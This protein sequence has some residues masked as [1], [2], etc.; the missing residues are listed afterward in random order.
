MPRYPGITS[1]AFRHPLDREAEQAL[2]ALPGFDL[3]ARKFLEFTVDRPQLIYNMGNS[4]QVGPRQYASVYQI[5]RE[6]LQSL[7]IYPEPALF[8]TQTP[9]VNAYTV[10][11]E[12]PSV[13]VT[14]GALDLLGETELR[15]VIAHELGHF[16]CGHTTLTQM[17]IWAIQA[18]S[19]VGQFTFGISNILT[20]VALFSAFY[21]WKRKAELS[22]DRA[23][24]LVT[25][26]LDAVMMTLIMLAGGSGS[27][28]QEISLDEF[29]RQAR[30]YQALDDDGLNQIYKFLL[31]NNLSQGVFTSH[32]FPVERVSFIE[33]W[34]N[35]DEYRRIRNGDYAQ[36]PAEGSVDISSNG[37]GVAEAERLRQQIEELQQQIN[38][39][40]NDES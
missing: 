35:S 23:A 6:C 5:Y 24:L 21:E 22:S 28:A 9:V 8:V 16:K 20:N 14:S 11:Q 7:D 39:I 1:D 2:R 18:A 31:Y 40:R 10:G 29:K 26:D 25:D 37:S 34:A 30:D 4:I 36:N 13:V 38:Q 33:E 32:P 3:I 27:R 19:L 15:A 12:Q 17:A